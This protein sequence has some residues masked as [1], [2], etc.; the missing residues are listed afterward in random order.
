MLVVVKAGLQAYESKVVF[1][2]VGNIGK[3]WRILPVAD[4]LVIR[5]SIV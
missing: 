5:F 4:N 1:A 3:S 2:E